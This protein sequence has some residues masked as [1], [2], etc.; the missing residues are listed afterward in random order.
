MSEPEYLPDGR[1]NLSETTIEERTDKGK[2]A[3]G[4]NSTSTADR[5]AEAD[6]IARERAEYERGFDVGGMER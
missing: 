2:A 1:P 6:R 4:P 3:N 5:Q